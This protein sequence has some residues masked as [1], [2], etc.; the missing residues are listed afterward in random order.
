MHKLTNQT[1]PRTFSKVVE[2]NNPTS[3]PR[4]KQISCN[5]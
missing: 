1:V 2:K 5:F 3:I 4:R